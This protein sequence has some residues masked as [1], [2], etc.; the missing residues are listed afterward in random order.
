MPCM[1]SQRRSGWFFCP[2]LTGE[3]GNKDASDWLAQDPARA[4]TLAGIC[5]A[6]PLWAPDSIIEGM[7]EAEKIK[8][9]EVNATRPARKKLQT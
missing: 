8:Q 5:V 6:A 2:G 1:T 7:A 3:K 4:D 9:A